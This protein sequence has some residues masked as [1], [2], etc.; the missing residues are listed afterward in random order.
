MQQDH[1]QSLLVQAMQVHVSFML[2]FTI[3]VVHAGEIEGSMLVDTL[4]VLAIAE[5]IGGAGVHHALA[6]LHAGMGHVQGAVDVGGALL[7][8]KRFPEGGV[9]SDME[10]DV[11]VAHR[12]VHTLCVGDVE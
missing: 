5:H 6:V 4:A 1:I 8:I 3:V 11:D 7:R 10:N 9:A 12:G 2:G